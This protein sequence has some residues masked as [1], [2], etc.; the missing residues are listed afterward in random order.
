MSFHFSAAWKER[1]FV[2]GYGQT[3]VLE[4]DPYT[5]NEAYLPSEQVWRTKAPDGLGD[6]WGELR[7]DMETWCK[8]NGREMR[9]N[10]RATVYQ[11]FTG[12]P[13]AKKPSSGRLSLWEW[14]KKRD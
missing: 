4:D 1:L 6:K 11:E 2:S 12:A 5:T 14:L 9:I 8:A 7:A 13:K 3:F 10:D